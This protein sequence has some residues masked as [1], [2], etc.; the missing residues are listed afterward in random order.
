M[1]ASIAIIAALLLSA[2][3]IAYARNV[4][5]VQIASIVVTANPGGH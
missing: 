1:K 4:N 2:V 3:T 5:D